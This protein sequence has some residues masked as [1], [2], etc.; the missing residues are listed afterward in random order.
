MLLE[1]NPNDR[2][3]AKTLLSTKE[4]KKIVEE[5]IISISK[6]DSGISRKIIQQSKFEL[7]KKNELEAQINSFKE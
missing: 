5:L 7:S 4:I 6:S 2:P 3:D 1:K